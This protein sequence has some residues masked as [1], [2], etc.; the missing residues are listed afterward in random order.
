MSKTKV[1]WAAIVINEDKNVIA[2]E[3]LRI[4]CK[5]QFGEVETITAPGNT[6]DSTTFL[7][8]SAALVV[9]S[10]EIYESK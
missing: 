4:K 1:I 7:E 6:T 10:E 2:I 8:K 3:P 5:N 9:V